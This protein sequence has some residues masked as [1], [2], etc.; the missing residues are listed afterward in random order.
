MKIGLFTDPHYC[1]ADVLNKTR[2]PRLSIH[3]IREAL[4]TFKAAEVDVCICLGDIT[5]HVPDSTKEEGVRC[6]NEVLALIKACEL[7]FYL[8]PG[9]HDYK[10]L[11][12]EEIEEALSFPVPPYTFDSNGVRFIALDANYRS[13]M[14]R[15][16]VAGVMWKDT[17]LPQE[18]LD[19]LR[20]ELA[21]SPLPCVVLSHE[22]LDPY[23]PRTDHIVK[24]A[25]EV[26]EIINESGKVVAVLQG[27]YH[28]GADNIVDGIRYLTLPAMC[29]GENNSFA[30][31][32][33]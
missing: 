13:D 2:R 10:V 31:L 26:R 19:F 6:F 4:N 7:P 18:Q 27:H 17:N 24:N 16:D 23:I 14:R 8:V 1:D 11:T 29:E 9:N 22:N 33:F 25:H 20:R 3:K 21:S 5:D 12:G 28:K 32:E 15:F 30:I